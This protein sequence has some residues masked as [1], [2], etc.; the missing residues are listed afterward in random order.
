MLNFTKFGCG[1][2]KF[3]LGLR[4]TGCV[5]A[6]DTVDQYD[7]AHILDVWKLQIQWNAEVTQSGLVR[8]GNARNADRARS[9]RLLTPTQPDRTGSRDD[10][11]IYD[12]SERSILFILYYS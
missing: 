11:A 12:M 2:W 1:G 4:Y 7:H 9:C 5:A 8:T 3:I 10:G 6:P